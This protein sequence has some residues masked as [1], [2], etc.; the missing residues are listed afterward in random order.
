M[1]DQLFIQVYNKMAETR[2]TPSPQWQV[3]KAP[4]DQNL[5]NNIVIYIQWY[6]AV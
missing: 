2:H 6:H 5:A 1:S 4:Q 3:C